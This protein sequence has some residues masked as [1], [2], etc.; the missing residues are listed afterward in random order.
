MVIFIMPSEIFARIVT[1]VIGERAGKGDIIEVGGHKLSREWS[2]T[3]NYKYSRLHLPTWS[4]SPGGRMFTHL[5]TY[6]MKT[7]ERFHTVYKNSDFKDFAEKARKV[8]QEDIPTGE[9]YEK[10][11]KEYKK[12]SY[13]IGIP[14]HIMTGL[15]SAMVLGQIFD[16]DWDEFLTKGIG[17]GV[18]NPIT[19]LVLGA[20]GFNNGIIQ[21]AKSFIP[22]RGAVRTI[23]KTL[24]LD[25]LS[26]YKDYGYVP[27]VLK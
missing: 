21:N 6:G 20:G 3:W 17:F 11:W 2:N 8:Y 23:D 22:F 26:N 5:Q 27:K 4:L 15:I 18:S 12:N 24:G 19:N 13:R 1:G 16:L 10:I 14:K 7:A 9:K 25:I